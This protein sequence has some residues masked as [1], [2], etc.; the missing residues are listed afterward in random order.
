MDD[1]ERQYVFIGFVYDVL[2]DIVLGYLLLIV[3]EEGVELVGHEFG[4]L[5]ERYAFCD[6]FDW[7][8]ISFANG[9]PANQNLVV[10]FVFFIKFL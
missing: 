4:L 1:V 9:C 3:D 2:L 5:V 10:I 7:E 8:D 6:V